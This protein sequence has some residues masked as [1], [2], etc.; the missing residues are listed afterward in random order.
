MS[1]YFKSHQ[2]YS[3]PS[4]THTKLPDMQDVRVI[5]PLSTA[6]PMQQPYLPE[7][8]PET[9]VPPCLK[10]GYKILPEANPSDPTVWGPAFW[11]S[12]HNGASQYPVSASPFWSK[13]MKA[14]IEGIPVMLP[15]EKCSTHAASFIDAHSDEIEQAVR[16]RDSL[17]AFFVKFHNFV[18]ERVGKPTITLQ[19][20][21]DI[22]GGS[23]NVITLEF[24]K[25]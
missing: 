10:M 23:A 9:T 15:C 18:N 21:L 1:L 6:V 17:F 22:F 20:A 19:E 13:R 3:L 7:P 2:V 4:E 12:L 16:G 25:N 11:F 24:S 5:H 14:F 8:E